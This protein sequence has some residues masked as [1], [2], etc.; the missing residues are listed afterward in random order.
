MQP[1]RTAI[2]SL[3]VC[4]LLTALPNH[5][6]ADNLSD[7]REYDGQ[8][9]AFSTEIGNQH[10]NVADMQR[11]LDIYARGGPAP[12]PKLLRAMGLAGVG[13][14]G[15]GK[16]KPKV[17][18]DFINF[19]ESKANPQNWTGVAK[20]LNEIVGEKKR[21]TAKRKKELGLLPHQYLPDA[22]RQAIKTAAI[23]YADYTVEKLRSEQIIARMSARIRDIR[24]KRQEA[25]NKLTAA[26]KKVYENRRAA[27]AAAA[28]TPPPVPP[29][30]GSTPASPTTTPSPPAPAP[31][32]PKND[33]ALIA[34]LDRAFAKLSTAENQLGSIADKGK[35]RC[36]RIADAIKPGGPN[37]IAGRSKAFEA[38]VD[39]VI[40][41]MRQD[42]SKDQAEFTNA[43]NLV[44]AL[45]KVVD[46]AVDS[47]ARVCANS[48][49][50]APDQ[51][52]SLEGTLK[53][54]NLG[55]LADRIAHQARQAN[56][57]LFKRFS[58]PK[59]L[60]D[61]AAVDADLKT[62]A[63]DYVNF[64]S[65]FRKP[66]PT[67][68]DYD[69]LTRPLLN[70]IAAAISQAETGKLTPHLT[71]AYKDLHSEHLARLAAIGRRVSGKPCRDNRDKAEGQCFAR[72]AIYLRIGKAS[73]VVDEI[74]T[75][76]VAHRTAQANRV[77]ALGQRI[78]SLSNQQDRTAEKARNCHKVAEAKKPKI[79]PK[80]VAEADRLADPSTSAC[81]AGDLR[82]QAT[83]L[84][85]A[86]FSGVPGV[87]GK[88]AELERRAG[89]IDAAKA[90]YDRAKAAYLKGD[91]ASTL[92]D[93]DTAKGRIDSLGAKPDC[94]SVL[95]KIAKGRA[96]TERF[97]NVVRIAEETLRRC[98]PGRLQSNL[99]AIRDSNAK[100]K[101]PH[102]VLVGLADRMTVQT[103]VLARW[104]KAEAEYAA[105]R[106]SSARKIL[107]RIKAASS[108]MPAGDCAG[109]RRK[110]DSGLGRIAARTSARDR[111]DKVI[112]SCDTGGIKR[113]NYEIPGD[114]GTFASDLRALLSEGLKVC[115]RKEKERKVADRKT[116]C[117]KQNGKGYYPGPVAA[118]GTYY[119]LPTKA[120][121][122]AWCNANN[123][124]KGW[125][126]GKI[127]ARGGYNCNKSAKQQKAEN[128]A[129]C[130]RQYGRGYYAGKANKKG[131]YYCRP[132]RKTAH[133]WCRKRNG[134]GAYAGK[135]R[136]N[137]S[138]NCY[139]KNQ[140]GT[141]KKKARR[142]PPRSHTKHDSAAAAAIMQGIIGTI[143]N[144]NQPRDRYRPKQRKRTPTYTPPRTRTPPRRT[145]RKDHCKRLSI[146]VSPCY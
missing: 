88:I 122:N 19:F 115:V 64:C 66:V 23:G 41:G 10:K 135:V 16:S 27:A 114:D 6:S 106:L 46:K 77:K 40:A 28:P 146:A 55:V 75:Q 82:A 121:A 99:Q 71:A 120:T 72:S 102:P 85:D 29:A 3:L 117:L 95:T 32:A 113:F 15:P 70:E 22:D 57:T 143:N 8:I 13:V 133:A 126:A 62:R 45:E 141:P 87:G 24:K 140:A 58:S 18:Q 130:R 112:K 67:A 51:K 53:T 30:G 37:S 61:K 63:N 144:L 59:A 2:A 31:P 84:R 5:A 108:S 39:A 139:R 145:G 56:D 123:K 118:D 110:V 44:D 136:R 116:T 86:R 69:Y 96:K 91:T 14:V 128:N 94:T 98:K 100:S 111:A 68:A 105:G 107:Q 42:P 47:A 25:Y 33:R 83:Q 92:S 132:T 4:L 103:S 97:V 12:D 17:V 81:K 34:R 137:G 38:S 48:L 43:S 79:D 20:K 104:K 93:L 138:F 73:A 26:E 76:L 131:V 65:Q 11:H 52:A 129:N 89:I 54:R 134:R 119:C 50:A 142:T 74:I 80:L 21:L 90:D 78:E 124:G 127:G 109:L 101:S 36:E 7:L 35:A 49:A 9:A 125:K 60:P 1:K